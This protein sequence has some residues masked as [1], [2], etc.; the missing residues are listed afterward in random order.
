MHD[1]YKLFL[2]DFCTW[3]LEE[4]QKL[5][6]SR[7]LQS[8][9]DSKKATFSDGEMATYYRIITH[10]KNQAEVFELDLKFLQLDKI[11]PD[12]DLI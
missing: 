7:D 4:A 6:R 11:E 9:S 10:L 2:K 3:L 8:H 12:K 5:R 1:S